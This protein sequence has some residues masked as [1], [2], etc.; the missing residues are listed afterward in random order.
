M[1]TL[2]IGAT[3]RATHAPI[4]IY[5]ISASDSDAWLSRSTSSMGPPSSVGLSKVRT[6]RPFG[7]IFIDTRIPEV[8]SLAWYCNTSPILVLFP[9]RPRVDLAP[10]GRRG[11]RKGR[12]DQQVQSK[13]MTPTIVWNPTSFHVINVLGNGC[14][15]T[16]L[17]REPKCCHHWQ[18]GAGSKSG[19]PIESWSPCR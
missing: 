9:D 10:A 7:R 5:W 6:C 18:N 14:N 17:N 3:V 4:T 13:K 11:G 19:D 1:R 16:P 15:S 8:K 12:K 2:P